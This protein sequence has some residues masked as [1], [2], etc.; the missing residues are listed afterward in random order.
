MLTAN[1]TGLERRVCPPLGYR[2]VPAR[3]LAADTS[4]R[5]AYA[6]WT[7]IGAVGTVLM[8]VML[9]GETLNSAR[10]G[11]ITLVLTGIV[12]LRLAPA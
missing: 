3:S 11:G 8:G 6:V 7:G 9:F 4:G 5:T 1:P 10:L 2:R 12:A